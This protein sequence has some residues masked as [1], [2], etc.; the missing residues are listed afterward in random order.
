MLDDLE[1]ALE[2]AA[3]HEEAKLEEG[4]R[5]VHRELLEALAREGLV[6]VETEGQ[7]DP[8][9]HEALLLAALRAG[10]RLRHWR[11]CRRATASA[12]ASC[13]RPE[14]W[15]RSGEQ[16]DLYEVLG[17][18]KGAPAEE[19]KNA[20]RKLARQHHPDKN[21]GDKASEE[22]FKEIQGAYDVLFDPEKRKQYDQAGPRMFSGAGGGPGSAATSIFV[23]ELLRPRRHRRS[24]RKHFERGRSPRLLAASPARR[25]RARRRG[26]DQRLLRGLA[27]RPDDEDPC[28]P[29][30]HLL[31]RHGTGAEPGSQ[32]QI[33]PEVAAAGS[34][35]RMKASSRSRVPAPAATATGRSSR[36]R[37]G[38]ATAQ[39]ASAAR[40]ATP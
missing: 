13:A 8:H 31:R 7:F 23:R 20:Y 22:R 25:T 19:I 26:G 32:P 1:R 15:C 12:T 2:A 10:G 33:C 27:Q 29:R 35:Q 37:A 9:V 16:A 17:V 28:R 3:Q 6:E 18:K 14:S 34:F 36:G 30:G 11:S 21:P 40:S 39:A 24:V 4:V 38:T 5:L